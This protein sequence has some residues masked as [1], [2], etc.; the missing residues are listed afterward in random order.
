MRHFESHFR[1][2]ALA[3]V[4]LLACGG[5]SKTTG[6]PNPSAQVSAIAGTYQTA[7]SLTSNTCTGITVQN[8]PTTVAHTSGSAS[9]TLTHAG[10]TYNGT[11]ASNNS[12]TTQ[13]KAIVV[14]TVTH[15]LTIAGQFTT[16]GF[17]ADV[18][19]PVTGTGNG[20]PC[21]Y[22]VRWVGTK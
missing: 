7:V 12:F 22:V 8:N 17:T 1:P 4:F 10:Q 3:V 20:A 21:Q 6:T 2:V 15:T 18:T 11:L 14:G 9:L 5:G 16:N 13:A 19:V